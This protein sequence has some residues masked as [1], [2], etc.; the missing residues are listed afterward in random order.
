MI[1]IEEQPEC[2]WQGAV[3]PNTKQ[4]REAFSDTDRFGEPYRMYRL[5]EDDKLMVPRN[6]AP[7]IDPSTDYRDAGSDEFFLNAFKP[8]NREQALVVSECV[9]LLE[10]GVSHIVQA[11]TGFGKTYVGCA[12]AAEI[13][14]RTIVITTKQDIIKQWADAAKAVLGLKAS[15]IGYIQGDKNSSEG[16]PFVIALVQS[17]RKGPERYDKATFADFGLAIFDEVHRMGAEH[18]SEVCWHLN[19]KLR[20]GLSAT[21]NRKD[22]REQVFYGHIGKVRVVGTQNS[23]VPDVVR[24]PT[25]WEVPMVNWGGELK[26]LPHKPG[27]LSKLLTAMV[28]S[29]QRNNLLCKFISAAYKKGRNI[30]VF[31]D[32]VKHLETLQSMM[33]ERG[34]GEGAMGLYVGLQY[35]SGNAKSKER[36]REAVKTKRIIFATYQMCAEATDIPW[37]D[38]AVLGTPRSDVNQIV[39]RIRR[40]FEGKAK[41][42]VFDPVDTSSRVLRSYATSRRKWYESIGAEIRLV[43]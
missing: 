9:Q 10:A 17:A 33:K 26:Q 32:Q 23:M 25:H 28:Q 16:K 40:E 34:V 31:S 42:I 18:F 41:P 22:G 13:G 19:A 37:L 11:M 6:C 2:V 7:N 14:K 30:I 21:P 15:D 12:A 43:G 4:L 8:R 24:S 38:T 36:Q 20:L 27:R 29:E 1:S 5:L 39:G 35:Y 3:Y